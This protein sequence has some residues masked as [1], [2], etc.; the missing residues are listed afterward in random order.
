MWMMLGETPGAPS[1][2][3]G[4]STHSTHLTGGHT[5]TTADK[6]SGAFLAGGQ[7]KQPAERDSPGSPGRPSGWAGDRG[8]GGGGRRVAAPREMLQQRQRR[9]HLAQGYQQVC[10]PCP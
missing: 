10:L 9:F 3:R 8:S 2:P 7:L 1:E 6:F 4:T 5:P